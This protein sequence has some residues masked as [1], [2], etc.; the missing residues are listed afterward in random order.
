LVLQHN[1]GGRLS[2]G[3]WVRGRRR[4]NGPRG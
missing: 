2:T 1:T 3:H 4:F